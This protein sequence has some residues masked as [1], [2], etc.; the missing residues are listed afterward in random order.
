M[1]VDAMMRRAGAAVGLLA[2][3]ATLGWGAPVHEKGVLKLARR[4]LAAGDTVAIAGQ[5]FAPNGRLTLT[6][7]GT[8]GR[9]LLGEVSADAAGAFQANVRVPAG[10]APGSYRLV[11][12]AADGDEVA[13]LDVALSAPAMTQ[14]H[15]PGEHGADSGADQAM[16]SAQPLRLARARSPAVTGTAVAGIIL[17]LGL[18][19]IW[20]R[21]PR[22]PDQP[23]TT[24]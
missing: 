2:L 1:L 13:S 10:I 24:D 4:E 14:Q 11:A 9:T 15:G 20:G 7:V 16:P 6:L 23:S 21:K 18:A 17:M 19:G 5:K 8:G 12:V 22:H 3:F